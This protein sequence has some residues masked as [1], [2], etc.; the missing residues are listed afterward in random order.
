MV[1]SEKPSKRLAAMV[2]PA[3]IRRGTIGLEARTHCRARLDGLLIERGSGAASLV[4][5]IRSDRGEASVARK[6]HRHQP[7]ERPNS[8]IRQCAAAGA[9]ATEDKRLRQPGVAV[10]QRFLEPRPLR[11][12]RA[13]EQIQQAIGE[14]GA[15][16]RDGA[17]ALKGTQILVDSEKD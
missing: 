15:N 7:V 16:R 4:E 6:L 9:D 14:F 17:V 8:R 3:A 13:L 1:L 11:T 5:A 2:H 10:R 12:L